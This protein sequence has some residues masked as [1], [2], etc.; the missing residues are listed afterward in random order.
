MVIGELAC[1]NLQ[2]RQQILALLKKLPPAVEATHGEVFYCFD[3][4]KL[5]G[6]GVGFVDLHLLASTLLSP[7]T[8]LWTRDRR[9][10]DV[11]KDLKVD[12]KHAH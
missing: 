7:N 3:Q 1:G 11:A 4:Y 2:N 5:M 6:K 10:N 12:W 8:V 9:L